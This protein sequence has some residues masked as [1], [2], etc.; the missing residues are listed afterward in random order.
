MLFRSCRQ[1]Q[2]S[3]ATENM[4]LIA[5]P[6]PTGGKITL[7]FN[8]QNAENA[9]LKISDLL[10]RTVQSENIKVQSGSNVQDT[11]LSNLPKGIYLIH[12][13]GTDLNEVIK[14]TLD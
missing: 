7:T 2:V 1:S 9:T 6:N 11:D 3:A 5:F 4:K 12:L 13:T 14:V 10:G 8:A